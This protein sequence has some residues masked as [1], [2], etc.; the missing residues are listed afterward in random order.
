M[1]GHT[2]LLATWQPKAVCRCGRRVLA[3]G[4]LLVYVE[5]VVLTLLLL[6][7]GAQCVLAC[8][9]LCEGWLF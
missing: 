5:A 8:L 9:T 3:S 2:G 4:K 1:P 7:C 6:V